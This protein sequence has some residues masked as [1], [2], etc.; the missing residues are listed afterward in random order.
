MTEA[1]PT[2]TQSIGPSPRDAAPLDAPPHEA[3]PPDAPLIGIRSIATYQYMRQGLMIIAFL[4][5]FVLW[6]WGPVL[7]LVVAANLDE[8]L[9]LL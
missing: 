5:P 8:L 9:L 6:G 3:S 2:A 1:T 7:D 4:L